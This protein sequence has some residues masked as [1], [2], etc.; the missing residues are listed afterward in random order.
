MKEK[1][2]R[3][4][5]RDKSRSAGKKVLYL[6][7]LLRSCEILWTE[8]TCLKFWTRILMEGWLWAYPQLA[9]KI[10]YNLYCVAPVWPV[11]IS[12]PSKLKFCTNI[13][14]NECAYLCAK[15]YIFEFPTYYFQLCY[16]I[17]TSEQRLLSLWSLFEDLLKPVHKHRSGMKEHIDSRKYWKI[18]GKNRW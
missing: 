8:F 9:W 10:I 14:W 5:L 7:Y 4:R 3:V 18:Y 15:F 16:I 12:N 6:R 1:L 11:N 2:W 17:G 13:Y